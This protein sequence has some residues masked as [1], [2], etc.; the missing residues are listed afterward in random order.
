MTSPQFKQRWMTLG[1]K[2][3]NYQG[4]R[5]EFPPGIDGGNRVAYGRSGI[6][7]HAM[8]CFCDGYIVRTKRDG[9]LSVFEVNLSR[10]Q[11]PFVITSENAF[12]EKGYGT[13]IEGLVQR[14]LP[15]PDAIRES[16]SARFI[17]DPRFVI[18]VNGTALSLATHPGAEER[19]PLTVPGCGEIEATIVDTQ[20]SA[21]TK[22]KQGL[23]LGAG[24]P[25][26]RAVV[27]PRQFDADRREDNLWQTIHDSDQGRLHGERTGTRLVGL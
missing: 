22:Q 13:T 20:K 6:G 14:N 5:V 18:S 2:R 26:R 10:G 16:I 27:D 7:R 9:G 23:H 17:H 4:K 15:D 8:L 12:D 24:P 19:V 11:H 3:A 25:G 21:R 1:Y